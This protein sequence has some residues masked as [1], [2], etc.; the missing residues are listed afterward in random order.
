MSKEK[1]LDVIEEM[2]V[3]VDKYLSNTDK[4]LNRKRRV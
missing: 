4:I 2:R 3:Q 1:L